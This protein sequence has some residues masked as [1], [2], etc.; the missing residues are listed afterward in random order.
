VESFPWQYRVL[1]QPLVINGSD[2]L[3]FFNGAVDETAMIVKSVQTNDM[4]RINLTLAD[5]ASSLADSPLVP[6]SVVVAS[7]SSLGIIYIENVDYI[8]DY[9]AAMLFVKS[10]S[11]LQSGNEVVVWYRDYHVYTSG[12]DYQLQ[13]DRG[14][15]RRL[16]SGDIN[17]GETVYLD[18]K[19]MRQAYNQ[20]I[21]INAVVMAN[22]LIEKEVDPVGDFG[23]DPTLQAAATYRA[24]EIVCQVSAVRDLSI[25]G[26][27][28]KV[29]TDWIKLAEMFAQRSQQL[30]RSFHPPYENPMSPSHG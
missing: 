18:Y 22:G 27:R 14:E 1:D 13:A 20:D 8:I 4:I 23:A 16:S 6:G 19:P 12:I 29:G 11:A 10:S 24:L 21:I 5:G 30:L 17:D 7:D 2:Y 28:E 3:T 15:I 26:G 25:K 9:T